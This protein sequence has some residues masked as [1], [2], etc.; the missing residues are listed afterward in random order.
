M[1]MQRWKSFELHDNRKYLKKLSNHQLL[2]KGHVLSIQLADERN[3]E[4]EMTERNRR[5]N[6]YSL[7]AR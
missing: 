4:G 3:N 1:F 6:D 7:F 2:K 5:G